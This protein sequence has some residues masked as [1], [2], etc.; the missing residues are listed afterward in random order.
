MFLHFSYIAGIGLLIIA[1]LWLA[2]LLGEKYPI[3]CAIGAIIIGA[4]FVKT[5]REMDKE[6]EMEKKRQEEIWQKIQQDSKMKEE[7]KR[8]RLKEITIEQYIKEEYGN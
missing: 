7:K 4:W 1:A 6:E 8:E 3:G 5:C 2:R